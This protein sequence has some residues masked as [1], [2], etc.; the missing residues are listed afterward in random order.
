MN[1]IYRLKNCCGITNYIL[2]LTELITFLCSVSFSFVYNCAPSP[3]NADLLFQSQK[4]IRLLSS[5]L[6]VLEVMLLLLI[7]K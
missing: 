3:T 4:D 2:L 5:E 1:W 7:C 6:I